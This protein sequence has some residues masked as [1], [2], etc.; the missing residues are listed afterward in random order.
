MF[1]TLWI[2]CLGYTFSILE[3]IH[4]DN[5]WGFN[6]AYNHYTKLFTFEASAIRLWYNKSLIIIKYNKLWEI[7]LSEITI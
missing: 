6:V 5:F 7:S 2:I 4:V 3:K 1:I